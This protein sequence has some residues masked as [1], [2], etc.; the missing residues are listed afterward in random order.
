MLH[1]L[2]YERRVTGEC[3]LAMA[4]GVALNCTMNGSVL[5]SGIFDRVFVQPASHDAGC[6]MGAALAACN[7]MGRSVALPH[8]YL[9]RDTGPAEQTEQTLE[10]WPVQFRPVSDPPGL[11]LSISHPTASLDG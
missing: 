8:V 4:G 5:A 7:G 2:R 10:R 3:N 9:G 1:L 11:R 6:A